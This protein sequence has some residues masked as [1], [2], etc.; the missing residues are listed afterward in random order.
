M[1]D[2]ISPIKE[3]DSQI[4]RAAKATAQT[5][6]NSGDTSFKTQEVMFQSNVQ[7]LSAIL[8]LQ[9]ENSLA[10]EEA[11]EVEAQLVKDWN[12]ERRLWETEK[13]EYVKSAQGTITHLEEKIELQN[14]EIQGLQT[15]SNLRGAWKSLLSPLTSTSN[16]NSA[17]DE[18]VKVSDE[19]THE[20]LSRMLHKGASN[21]ASPSSD[22]DKDKKRRN[23]NGNVL[24]TEAAAAALCM[25]S[26]QLAR[27]VISQYADKKDKIQEDP[28]S[29]MLKVLEN[30]WFL[31]GKVDGQ[32]DGMICQVEQLKKENAQLEAEIEEASRG[33]EQATMEL[34]DTRTTYH[35]LMSMAGLPMRFGPQ[36]AIKSNAKEFK[37]F[38]A[39]H[40]PLSKSKTANVRFSPA[41][42]E[43]APNSPYT[44]IERGISFG[45]Y[46]PMSSRA[47]VSGSSKHA[48]YGSPNSRVISPEGNSI[49]S[50]H[51]SHSKARS[52]SATFRSPSHNCRTTNPAEQSKFSSPS[53]AFGGDN[54]ST[55]TKVRSYTNYLHTSTRIRLASKS[56]TVTEGERQI[57]QEARQRGVTSVMMHGQTMQSNA[58]A[59]S[60]VFKSPNKIATKAK[61]STTPAATTIATVI[62]PEEDKENIFKS[63]INSVNSVD[64]LIK[65][66]RI[67]MPGGN[68]FEDLRSLHEEMKD[69]TVFEE[70]NSYFQEASRA[71]YVIDH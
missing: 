53:Y 71:V 34:E 3:M 23:G 49:Y 30:V 26:T 18:K 42:S 11:R 65:N 22:E 38:P 64:S 7:C 35:D 31:Q 51:S 32:M 48:D 61:E 6:R 27:D 45:A 46:T 1:L 8:A 10:A 70:K 14:S 69:R 13:A 19:L 37:E 58:V 47:N 57:R 68:I 36:S 29:L 15:A 2:G 5:S 56:P 40:T 41:V 62:T 50:S 20:S 9:K 55:A 12:A 63:S 39:N 59:P 25:I 44:P 21:S 4:V 43:I 54:A 52:T 24:D 16:T 60:N 67:A 17:N 66:N 33:R 28:S